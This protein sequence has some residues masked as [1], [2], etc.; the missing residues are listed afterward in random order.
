M[1]DKFSG[2]TEEALKIR[3]TLY[4]SN[5]SVNVK[6]F[7]KVLET[8]KLLTYEMRQIDNNLYKKFA[9]ITTQ[10]EYNRDVS[11]PDIF[12]DIISIEGITEAVNLIT[13]LMVSDIP[14][15]F[16]S[17]DFNNISDFYTNMA[18]NGNTLRKINTY[19]KYAT[20]IIKIINDVVSDIPGKSKLIGDITEVR[21]T[22]NLGNA[23]VI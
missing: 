8:L 13:D 19:V 15:L 21:L 3:E 2:V 17:V 1:S 14:E 9:N 7:K 22:D 20:S 10:V 12:S 11:T 6:T 18:R 16:K 4:S 5:V 23:V